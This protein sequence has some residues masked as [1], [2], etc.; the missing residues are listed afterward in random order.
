MAGG[1]ERTFYLK[2]M[3]L[4]YL[5]WLAV[6]ICIGMAAATMPTS[7]PAGSLDQRIPLVPLFVWP[8]LAGYVY[9]FLLLVSLKDWRRLNRAFL[10]AILANLS[11]YAVY[12][13]WPI[14]FPVP[15]LGSSLSERILAAH[16]ALDFSPGACKFPSMHVAFVWIVFLACWRQRWNRLGDGAMF[17]GAVLI[18]ASTLLVKK[19]ILADVLGGIVWAFAAWFAAGRLTPILDD[20]EKSAPAALKRMLRRAAPG[21]AAAILILVLIF[22]IATAMTKA[23]GVG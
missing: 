8:Y 17:W 16:N 22:G 2:A 12:F 18:S 4:A 19:H 21:M 9:P 11:A 7:N 20:P 23:S 5:V 14:A 10:A 1:R 3:L 6:F 13:L 15:D